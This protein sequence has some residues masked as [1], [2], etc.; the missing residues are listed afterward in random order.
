MAL[1]FGVNGYDDIPLHTQPKQQS[2]KREEER[3]REIACECVIREV[4]HHTHFR[5][6]RMFKQVIA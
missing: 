1:R 5:R 3:E 6:M 4:A 2:K